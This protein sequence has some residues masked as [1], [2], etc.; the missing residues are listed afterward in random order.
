LN[1]FRVHLPSLS[2]VVSELAVSLV[3]LVP[4]AGVVTLTTR[5]SAS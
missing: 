3:V 2:V 5:S 4:E 1:R